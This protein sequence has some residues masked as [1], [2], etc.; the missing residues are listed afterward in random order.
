MR[1]HIGCGCCG[2][3]QCALTWSTLTGYAGIESGIDWELPAVHTGTA[4]PQI[5][6]ITPGQS[7]TT[8]GPEPPPSS[9]WSTIADDSSKTLKTLQ[10]AAQ[11]SSH[12]LLTTMSENGHIVAPDVTSVGV[13]LELYRWD[14]SAW[15]GS[16]TITGDEDFYNIDSARILIGGVDVSGW[17]SL[18]IPFELPTHT[19]VP[20]HFSVPLPNITIPART[21]VVCEIRNSFHRPGTHSGG[22]FIIAV[23]ESPSIN[24]AALTKLNRPGTRYLID[25]NGEDIAP[26]GTDSFEF[27][28]AANISGYTFDS[29][30]C[31]FGSRIG[32]KEWN[33]NV[34]QPARDVYAAYEDQKAIGFEV[35]NPDAFG[36][37]VNAIYRPA[38]DGSNSFGWGQWDGD[39]VRTFT[40]FATEANASPTNRYP[41]TI[42]VERL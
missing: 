28:S 14:E 10:L 13:A 32:V 40:R 36:N 37:D 34:A 4:N 31:G 3:S 29:T 41:A 8:E 39:G 26:D 15:G 7:T 27:G 25:F 2:S 35:V 21:S 1:W 11:D 30:A 19:R 33:L 22:K 18:D 5:T 24:W 38:D 17:V 6:L 12:S 42:T 16:Y 23:T 9:S 20:V